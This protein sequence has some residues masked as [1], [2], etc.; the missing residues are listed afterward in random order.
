MDDDLARL[1]AAPGPLDRL[2]MTIEHPVSGWRTDLELTWPTTGGL[3]PLTVSF[4]DVRELHL[5]ATS[6]MVM[7]LHVRRYP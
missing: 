7:S 3:E 5:K 1:L 6:N 2:V 4:E